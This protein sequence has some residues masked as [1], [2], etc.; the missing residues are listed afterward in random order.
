MFEIEDLTNVSIISKKSYKELPSRKVLI[1]SEGAFNI[2][3]R[4]K[5]KFNLVGKKQ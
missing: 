5:K 4:N 3:E 2:H 1:S